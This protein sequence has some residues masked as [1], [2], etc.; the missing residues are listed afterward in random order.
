VLQAMK[1]VKVKFLETC[2][3]A[4]RFVSILETTLRT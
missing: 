4:N 3:I 2:L 1:N